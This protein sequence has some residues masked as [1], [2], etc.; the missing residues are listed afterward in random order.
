[1]ERLSDGNLHST[2]NL[3]VLLVGGAGVGSKGGRY[4][5]YPSGTPIT[6]LYL[7]MLGYSWRSPWINSA[8]ALGGSPFLRLLHLPDSSEPTG[9]RSTRP[10]RSIS[11]WHVVVDAC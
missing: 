3:P 1:M 11:I 7:S 10:C 2:D 6:N 4:V 5:R 8:I 9:T